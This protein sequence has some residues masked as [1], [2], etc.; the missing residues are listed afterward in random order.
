MEETQAAEDGIYEIPLGKRILGSTHGSIEGALHADDPLAAREDGT[1]REFGWIA[2]ALPQPQGQGRYIVEFLD[3]AHVRILAYMDWFGHV[4]A[5]REPITE[6]GDLQPLLEFARFK[7]WDED[8]VERGFAQVLLPD[9]DTRRVVTYQCA[10]GRYDLLG[11][12]YD[13]GEHARDLTYCDALCRIYI[14]FVV[15]HDEADAPYPACGISFIDEAFLRFPAGRALAWIVEQVECGYAHEHF[16]VPA[17]AQ[18]LA[19][20][21][22]HANESC[23]VYPEDENLR[24]VRTSKYADLYFVGAAND[25][26]FWL[27]RYARIMEASLNRVML[28]RR[29]L[30]WKAWSASVAECVAADAALG[31]AM[32]HAVAKPNAEG[33]VVGAFPMGEWTLRSDI[34]CDI[35]RL[36]APYRISVEFRVDAVHGVAAFAAHVPAPDEY[37]AIS[38]DAG[39]A[40]LEV[41]DDA[42]METFAQEF[43][44]RVGLACALIAFKASSAIE[45]V[46]FCAG[47]VQEA[48]G[49]AA[50]MMQPSELGVA[51]TACYAT[52]D[53]ARFAA[54]ARVFAEP[55]DARALIA[56]YAGESFAFGE[57]EDWYDRSLEVLA[58]ASEP[59]RYAAHDADVELVDDEF[60][61]FMQ[62]VFGARY[63]RDMRISA[64]A[65]RR[66][67][68][69]AVATRIEDAPS[70]VEGIARLRAIQAEVAAPADKE[71]L[72]CVMEA[73]VSGEFEC[74]DKNAVV[75]RFLGEDSFMAALAQANAQFQVSPDAAA[76]V[77]TQ[78]IEQSRAQ[79]A[80]IDDA[81]VVYRSFDTYASRLIY[82]L[83]RSGALTFTHLTGPFDFASRD[84]GKRVE[85]VPDSYLMCHLE[86]EHLL[87][88]SFTGSD[89]AVFYG[90]RAIEIAPTAAA[91]YRQMARALMLTG[92]TESAEHALMCALE[93][94][95]QPV[96]VAVSYYQ[97]G[98][99]LWKSGRPRAG[100]LCYLKSMQT[101]PHMA[102][103]AMAELRQLV[104]ECNVAVD[105]ECDIDEELARCGVVVSPTPDV[106]DAVFDAAASAVDAGL[107]AVGRALLATRLRY[108]SDDALVNVLRS[109]SD[110]T[111]ATD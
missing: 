103:Q 89:E 54:D 2:D 11:S 79:G 65:E 85:L 75:N 91:G 23:A 104:A 74:R 35:E 105:V 8:G 41:P 33:V 38:W 27:K 73:L 40:M 13:L 53:R 34:A 84:E 17:L 49:D 22:E 57:L 51:S 81:E 42:E 64:G 90:T 1:P 83:A 15:R 9:G 29:T 61:L 58:A 39:C 55:I 59:N 63:Y 100:S 110:P 21:I 24:L 95:V 30:G 111:S 97:L 37:D 82:N 16:R 5:T 44:M 72:N 50:D 93:L 66:S 19:E 10:G 4:Y 28:I 32:V 6:L 7:Q 101:S 107:F 36:A 71:A 60:P 62:G 86:A 70:S 69:E 47:Y 77:V 94:A 26:P 20:L 80:Y 78:A 67:R 109:L 43:A 68:A 76:A 87:E 106:L 31:D 88:R 45:R 25:A 99:V 48:R 108:R 3:K 56:D 12:W 18:M 14:A 96:D 102:V 52:F 92:D 98:Y 46:E